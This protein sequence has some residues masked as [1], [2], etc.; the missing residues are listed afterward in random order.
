M[1]GFLVSSVVSVTQILSTFIGILLLF[2]IYVYSFFKS[3]L[4][5]LFS[6]LFFLSWF[7]VSRFL[8]S[9][10]YLSEWN[11]MKRAPRN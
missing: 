3:G 5:C 9:F 4:T 6:S 7:L 2:L 11:E 1:V 8:H 10:F